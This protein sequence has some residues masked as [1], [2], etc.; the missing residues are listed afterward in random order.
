M[1]VR[2]V[3]WCVGVEGSILTKDKVNGNKW[4]MK[5]GAKDGEMNFRIWK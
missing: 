2:A 5:G 3:V 1:V 4:V